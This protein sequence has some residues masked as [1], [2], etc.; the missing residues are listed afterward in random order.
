MNSKLFFGGNGHID[1]LGRLI[2]L[3]YLIPLIYFSFKI[4][5]FTKLYKSVFNFFSNMFSRLSLVGIWLVVDLV[6]RVDVSHFRLS[7]HLL[8]CFY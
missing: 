8:D 6:D 4:K 7:I 5:Y 1:F 3:G 2:G